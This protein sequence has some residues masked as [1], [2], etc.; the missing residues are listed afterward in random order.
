[1]KSILHVEDSETMQKAVALMLTEA[2]VK[3]ESV[4]NGKLALD[5]VEKQHFDGIIL[6][7]DMPI[8]D[9]LEFLSKFNP[10]KKGTT[11]LVCSARHDVNSIYKAIELGASD[12]IMK[13]FTDDILFSKLKQLNLL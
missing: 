1:M 7:I 9:G 2:N 3:L 12:Y 4:S 5:L 13:P 10:T 8:I 6:D 11:V